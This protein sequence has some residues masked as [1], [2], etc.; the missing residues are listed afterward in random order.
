MAEITQTVRPKRKIGAARVLQ[1]IFLILAALISIFPFLWM[2][3]CATNDAVDVNRGTLL[4]GTSLMT[5]LRNLFAADRSFVRALINSAVISLI[6]TALALL[7]SSAAGYGLPKLHVEDLFVQTQLSEDFASAVCTVQLRLLGDRRGSIRATLLDPSGHIEAEHVIPAQQSFLSF[8]VQNPQLWSAECPQLYCLWIQVLDENGVVLEVVPQ[9]IGIRL[10]CMEDGI[11]KL[12]GKRIV[13]CGVNRHE[14]SARNG[15][16]ISKEEMRWDILTM[17]RHNIN[18]VRTSH[19]PNQNDFY[20]LCDLYGLYVMD[21]TNLETHGTWQRLGQVEADENT[22]PGDRPEWR[23]AVLARAKAMLERDKNYPCVLIWS[24][25][26]ESHGGKTIYEMSEWFRERDPGRLVHYEGV[27][28][29][30]RFPDTSDMESRM[31]PSVVQIEAYLKTE[32]DKPFLCC[33]YSHSMGNSNGGL[34]RYTQLAKREPRYQGGFI[35]DY[36]DQGLQPD[37]AA[38]LAFGGDFG[39]RPT[40]YNFCING[41][42]FADRTLSP[43]MAEVKACY[44]PFDLCCT[45]TE[46]T[47]QNRMLFTDTSRF[48]LVFSLCRDG[49]LLETRVQKSFPAISPQGEGTIPV[50]IAPPDAPGEYVLTV[51]MQ[52]NQPFP[53]AEMG[54]ELAFSQWVGRVGAPPKRRATPAPELIVGDVNYGIRGEGFHILFARDRCGISSY[55]LGG[56]ECI[57]PLL[58]IPRPNFW[59]APLDNDYGWGMPHRC[60]LWQTASLYPAVSLQSCE[61]EGD[62]VRIVTQYCFPGSDRAQATVNYRFFGDGAVELTLTISGCEAFGA[63]PDFGFLLCMPPSFDRLEWYGRGEEENDCDRNY[64][65]RIGRFQSTVALQQTPYQR[66]QDCGNHTDTRWFTVTDAQGR[67]FRISGENLDFSVLPHTPFEL[68]HA[69]QAQ[70]LPPNWHSVIRVSKGQMGVG[71]DDSWGAMPHPDAIRMPEDGMS[72]CVTIRGI[73]Q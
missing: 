69:Y 25:G 18:A 13:F 22:L 30:R 10:F 12:N 14:F 15:R 64:G 6:T 41:L 59:R 43:K 66:V 47:I 61:R 54:T 53:W 38:P 31:Y 17:K 42:V 28:H 50:P 63:M 24:C 58:G 40:D 5:N 9:T 29:D 1:Y 36:I 26:N 73:Q 27:F 35:W 7:V 4:P 51:S 45:L 71:G 46:L 52:L 67:G 56:V 70:N 11:M 32:S 65:S 72:F 68:E 44:Q 23:G 33:E 49:T 20:A 16:A 60:A 62:A 2:I 8:G 39:D 3:I 55:Q 21:E 37:P 48:Q 19:Y 57:A 34:F